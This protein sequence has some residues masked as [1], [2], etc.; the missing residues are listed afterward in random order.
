MALKLERTLRFHLACVSPT[1]TTLSF[2]LVHTV[3]LDR[4]VAASATKVMPGLGLFVKC[5]DGVDAD[6]ASLT[7]ALAKG[8]SLAIAPGGI[9]EMFAGYPSKGFGKNEEAAVLLDRKGFIK[10]A[11]AG[12][13]PIV[14]VFVFGNSSLF[15][16]LHVPGLQTV[17]KLLRASLVVMYGRGGLPFMPRRVPLRFVVG[18]PIWPSR[19]G[20]DRVEIMHRAVSDEVEKV[21]REGRG[22][23]G[24]GDRTLRLV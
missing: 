22:D 7:T 18:E 24:W 17:S 6:K 1:A 12:E 8:E 4:T 14:P 3:C 13:V 23:Y 9:A 5:I 19:G 15:R 16:R 21:F 11:V 10:L 2:V 20:G